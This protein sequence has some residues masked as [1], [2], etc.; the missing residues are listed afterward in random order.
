MTVV[1]IVAIGLVGM[2]I[3]DVWR[4]NPAVSNVAKSG[5]KAGGP[6]ES[7]PETRR[8]PGVSTTTIVGRNLF[9][10]ARGAVAVK[11]PPP[12]KAPEEPDQGIDGVLLLGTVIAGAERYAIMKVPPD[13]G[14]VSATQRRGVKGKMKSAPPPK[15]DSGPAVRR[16]RVGDSLRGYRVEDI[17]EQ[18]VVLKRGKAKAEVTID[19]TREISVPTRPKPKPKVNSRTKKRSERKRR[20][21]KT[22]SRTPQKRGDR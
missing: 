14:R 7:F 16:V 15:V 1:L 19:Y 4:E 9:D 20:S 18:K 21:R 8:V 17:E 2:G 3:Y 22:R 5:M 6:G 10:P 12:A 13:I 11:P